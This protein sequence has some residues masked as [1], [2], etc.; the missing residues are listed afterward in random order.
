MVRRHYR[1]RTLV[2]VLPVLSLFLFGVECFGQGTQKPT[3]VD[4]EIAVFGQKIHYVEAGSGPTV[5]LLHGLGGST[6]NW[7]FTIGALAE[8]YHVI[9]P[10]QIGF[11]KSDKP[12]IN[13]RIRTYVDFLDE[14][15]K[16]LNIEHATLLGNSMGGW[17][18]AAYA[19]AFPARVD[20]LI[21]V[22]S[23]GYPPPA[24]FDKQSLYALNPT[25]KE[26]MKA[27][28]QKVFFNKNFSSD[29]VVDQILAQRLAAGDG[30]TINMLIE[31]VIRN[32]DFLDSRIQSIKQPS[33]IIWGRED[34]LTPLSDGERFKRDIANSTLVVL[35]QCGHFPQVEKAAEF[36]AAVMKFLTSTP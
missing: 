9:A 25:T 17:I 12:L 21:L 8:K 19:V 7:M 3:I 30:Y 4:K 16:Q 18:A 29:A 22:D 24:G 6:Q 26:G 23:T 33:L 32:E 13:Y 2:L 15:W 36:N 27:M 1:F 20:R 31:S 11:G 5:I 14:F 34:R 10:D 35:D 28:A